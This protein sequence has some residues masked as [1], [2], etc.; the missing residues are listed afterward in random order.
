MNLD[1]LKNILTVKCIY[2]TQCSKLY[3]HMH[4]QCV[5]HT[6][7]PDIFFC[8]HLLVPKCNYEIEGCAVRYNAQTETLIQSGINY[9]AIRNHVKCFQSRV[10]RFTI[11][12][13]S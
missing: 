3:L 11:C 1:L 4:I 10:Q 13:V 9:S 12:A 2:F 5:H 8:F 6:L 7:V